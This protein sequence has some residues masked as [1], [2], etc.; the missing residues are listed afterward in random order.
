MVFENLKLRAITASER[1]SFG[2]IYCGLDFGWYPD[3]THFVK[4]AYFPGQRKLIIYDEFRTWKTSSIDLFKALMN[5][6]V[7]F[8]QEVV[9]DSAAP[10]DIADLASY[11]MRCIGATKGPGTPAMGIKWLQS[12]SEIIIDPVFCPATAK[13]FS[14]YEYERTRSG[15]LIASFPD[16]DNHSIDAVRYAT[17][18]IWL[19][20]G[21]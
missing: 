21:A 20:R 1:A 10:K 15:E 6:H 18:R 8:G 13:E 16:K 11:G 3:P 7:I 2:T 4:C 19:Q 9:A 12:L 17:N 5:G 14:T